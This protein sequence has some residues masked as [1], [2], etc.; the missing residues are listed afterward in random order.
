MGLIFLIR[1]SHGWHQEAR[2]GETANLLK[3]NGVDACFHQVLVRPANGQMASGMIRVGS[4]KESEC[5]KW[6]HPDFNE[7]GKSSDEIRMSD[8]VSIG[9]SS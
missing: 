1:I 9:V 2:F 5:P 3:L 4:I 8:I 6:D 7:L